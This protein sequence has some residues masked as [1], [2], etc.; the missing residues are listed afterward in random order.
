ML[1]LVQRALLYATFMHII[2]NIHTLGVIEL[3]G[4]GADL[5]V[6]VTG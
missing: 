5:I 2:I 6:E 3:L 1:S 4:R